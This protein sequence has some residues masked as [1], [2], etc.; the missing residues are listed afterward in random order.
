MRFWQLKK[1][2]LTFFFLYID[3]HQRSAEI[4]K[5]SRRNTVIPKFEFF[6]VFLMSS[7]LFPPVSP[8]MSFFLLL[9]L[10]LSESADATLCGEYSPSRHVETLP[11]SLS[12]TPLSS[13]C[14]PL[15][16]PLTTAGATGGQASGALTLVSQGLNC[17][18]AL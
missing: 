14:P 6:L 2:W 17:Q 13:S 16:P 8:V 7:G 18:S 1:V 9:E 10:F 3:V 4:S 12:L 5:I 11:G 15:P